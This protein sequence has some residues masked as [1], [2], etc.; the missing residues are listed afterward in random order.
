MLDRLIPGL[1]SASTLF[2]AP[3]IKF[4]STRI[5]CNKQL[6][7]KIKGLYIAGDG[8]GVSGNLVGAAATGIIAARDIKGK[9]ANA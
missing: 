9:L 6:E 7:T 8:T 1:A 4:F 5:E 2:Y 3:E